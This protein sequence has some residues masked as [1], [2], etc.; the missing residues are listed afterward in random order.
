MPAQGL[1]NPVVRRDEQ[2][3]LVIT[4]LLVTLAAL[5]AMFTAWATVVDARRASALLR[6]LG[7]TPR[8]VR[9]GLAD[10]QPI[11]ALP[12]VIVGVPLGLALFERAAGVW[13]DP[14]ALWLVATV[15]GTLPVV[16]ALTSLPAQ[17]GTR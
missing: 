11:S 9:I 14:S 15:F 5:T 13:A 7:A 12:G 10:A 4:I 17:V 2:A 6:A 3:L 16:A 1:G 8:Q